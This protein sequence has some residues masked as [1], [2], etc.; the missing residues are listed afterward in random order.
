MVS[1]VLYAVADGL[2]SI[3]IVLVVEDEFIIRLNAMQVVEDA[4]YIALEAA[5]ADEAM[6]ILEQRNDIDVVFTDINMPGSMDG[7]E[8][9]RAILRRWPPIALIVTSGKVLPT[10]TELPAGRFLPKPYAERQLKE[11]LHAIAA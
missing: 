2:M 6:R 4:G 1:S 11:A 5:N 7:L 9:A 10:A 8:M 3:E